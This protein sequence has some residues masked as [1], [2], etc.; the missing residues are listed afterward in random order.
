MLAILSA[1][2]VKAIVS[3]HRGAAGVREAR[4]WLQKPGRALAITLDGGAPRVA[5]PGVVR[6]ARLFGVSLH[7]LAVTA[8]S[9]FRLDGW[10]RGVV[11]HLGSRITV[12][13]L[14]P[15]SA[16]GGPNEGALALERALPGATLLP[17]TDAL[18]KYR[19]G[20]EVWP[21]L[22]TMPLAKGRLR[23]GSQE[24]LLGAQR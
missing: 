8:S 13:T 3:D 16:R 17:S 6:L 23:V 12:R 19:R 24:I 9:G 15:I 2:R 1:L 21:R 18:V 22:C 5:L 14:H 7:P 4:E 20:L 11:P 10:D